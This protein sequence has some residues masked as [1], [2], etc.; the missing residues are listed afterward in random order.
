MSIHFRTRTQSPVN[1]SKYLFPGVNGCCCTGSSKEGYFPFKS[2]FGECNGLGGYF[3]LTESS[4][5]DQLSCLPKGTTGCCCSCTH[6]GMADNIEKTQC[7]DLDG[8]WSPEPCFKIIDVL[9]FCTKNNRD[10]RKKR[11]CCGVTL[12]AGQTLTYCEDVC[13]ARECA[14]N[15]IGSF[16]PK[17]YVN[18]ERCTDY[19]PPQCSGILGN[20]D[21]IYSG[22][23][24]GNLAND[25]KGNCCIQDT[26]CRCIENIN[27]NDCNKL[28][29]SFYVL[30][31]TDFWCSSCIENCTRSE[32]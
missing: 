8:T 10:V 24:T 19:P 29:G 16:V 27:L 21:I 31:E 25:V 20:D 3:Q 18:G 2:T 17:F 12:T 28:G 4:S 1:Y 5:C 23:V 9:S 11:A 14:D 32:A 7:D 26:P 30:G 13:L 22:D 15:T 6:Q